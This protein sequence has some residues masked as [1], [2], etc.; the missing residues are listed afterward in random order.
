MGLLL[1]K[2]SPAALMITA[3]VEVTMA[4]F[5]F[6]S[7]W[8][9][10]GR[11]DGPSTIADPSIRLVFF[12]FFFFFSSPKNKKKFIPDIWS[13]CLPSFAISLSPRLWAGHGYTT[14]MDSILSPSVDITHF[15]YIKGKYKEVYLKINNK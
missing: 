12:S 3:L 8:L 13:V 2:E 10:D 7:G 5:F 1:I 14:G 15:I 6:L 11:H 4:L 9:A